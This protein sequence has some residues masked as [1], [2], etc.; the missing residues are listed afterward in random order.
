[1]F[2]TLIVIDLVFWILG[3]SEGYA[4][5]PVTELLSHIEFLTIAGLVGAVIVYVW[6]LFRNEN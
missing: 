6:N 4:H 1:M 5:P 3:V 2:G